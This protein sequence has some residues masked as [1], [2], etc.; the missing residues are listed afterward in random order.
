MA[1]I[2][3]RL[4]EGRT[5]GTDLR[6]MVTDIHREAAD[7]IDALVAVLKPAREAIA[8]VPVET[9]GVADHDGL[10]D[11]YPIQAELLHNIDAA[12]ALTTP[13]ETSNV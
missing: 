10:S 12:L 2:S 13:K 7:T 9:F 11:P 8:S 5:N 6:W 1:T 4:R 3:E